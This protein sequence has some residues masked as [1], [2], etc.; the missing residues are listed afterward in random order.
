M[1]HIAQISEFTAGF[2]VF[3]AVMVLFYI[4]IAGVSDISLIDGVTQA[5]IEALSNTDALTFLSKIGLLM[6]L[7]SG[8]QLFSMFIGIMTLILAYIII[9]EGADILPFFG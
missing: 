4:F 7:S 5:D 6:N 2:L 3:Y 9:K 1:V 8:F